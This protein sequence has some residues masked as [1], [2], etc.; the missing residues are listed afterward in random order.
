MSISEV[1]STQDIFEGEKFIEIVGTMESE[2]DLSPLKKGEISQAAISG[3]DWTVET[4]ISQINKGNIQLNPKF[5]RRDAW[6]PDR[7]SRFI[8]SLM[9]GFPVPQLVLAEAKGKK[10]SYLVIDGKQRLL[11]IRQFAALDDE[12]LF[13]QLRLK[14]LVLSPELNGKSLEDLKADMALADDLRAFENAPIRTVVIKN[15]PSESFLYHV[16]LRLNTGSLPLSPQEL[17]QALHPGLFVDFADEAAS[18]SSALKEILKN[19]KPDFRMRDVELLIRFFAFRR[20]LGNYTGDL[21]RMLDLTCENLNSSWQNEEAELR[22]LAQ[23]FE[24]AYEAA[25]SIFG[26]K[27]VFR[28]WTGQTYEARFNR[29]IFDVLMHYFAEPSVRAAALADPTSVENSFKS[30]CTSDQAFLGSI[31]KTTKSIDATFTRF[32]KWAQ[33]L[34][35][36]LGTNVYVPALVDGRII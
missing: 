35:A 2:Q 24:A 30:L 6:T 22:Q 21:K 17:R 4:I 27:N 1:A 18:N 34:N 3:A 26:L 29:A 14:D 11:S 28:K 7:K 8:E 20:F 10:G 33:A 31:E 12:Q 15:W 19:K 9:L 36:S 32:S 5:Q 25:R 16:F 23:E 13:T